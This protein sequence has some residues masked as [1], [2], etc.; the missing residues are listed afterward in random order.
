LGVEFALPPGFVYTLTDAKF[1][2]RFERDYVP[3]DY[4]AAGDKLPYVSDKQLTWNAGV[5][6]N[7]WGRDL[8]ANY[9]SDARARRAGRNR[10]GATHRGALGGGCCN[11]E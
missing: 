7:R 3:W 9:V 11:M 10:G 1:Q 5:E 2:R 8:S 4:V 6:T